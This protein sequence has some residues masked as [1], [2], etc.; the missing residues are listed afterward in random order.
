MEFH[1]THCVHLQSS[2]NLPQKFFKKKKISSKTHCVNCEESK[3]YFFGARQT[4]MR[5]S[6]L[7]EAN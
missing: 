3:R 2:R 6:Q 5:P 1:Q 4:A 7:A